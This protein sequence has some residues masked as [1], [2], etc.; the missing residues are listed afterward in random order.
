MGD[1]LLMES[2]ALNGD[3][4]PSKGENKVQIRLVKD[5]EIPIA[6][7]EEYAHHVISLLLLENPYGGHRNSWFG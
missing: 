5:E 6:G 4:S 3:D 7:P 2:G 1:P